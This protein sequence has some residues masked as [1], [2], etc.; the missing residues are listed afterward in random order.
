LVLSITTF[1]QLITQSHLAF[2]FCLFFRGYAASMAAAQLTMQ[3]AMQAEK[4]AVEAADS[5]GGCGE[6]YDEAAAKAVAA[7]R[8]AEAVITEVGS[9]NL[10]TG[11]GFFCS[12][13]FSPAL[14]SNHDAR[15]VQSRYRFCQ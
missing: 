8:E 12:L 5:A 14:T 6:P 4:D 1:F 9:I 7:Y 10:Q 11:S 13:S 2:H 3:T 15:F